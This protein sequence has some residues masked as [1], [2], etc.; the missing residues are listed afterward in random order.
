[1]SSAPLRISEPTVAAASIDDRAALAAWR[2]RAFALRHARGIRD[3]QERLRLR[4]ALAIAIVCQVLFFFGLQQWTRPHFEVPE[5]VRVIHL[6][7]IDPPSEPAPAPQAPPEPLA[8]T[9]VSAP[10][11]VR[12]EPA[13]RPAARPREAAPESRHESV[14]A[15]S[16]A[17]PSA[18]PVPGVFDRS[19]RVLL[20]QENAVG[21]AE[22]FAAQAPPEDYR[23]DPMAHLAP[24]PYKPTRFDK[25]W[26]PDDETLLGEWVRKATRK[27]VYDTRGGTRITC[28]AF[29]FFSACG[30]GP[31]PRVTI[32]EL[33]A[34]RVVPPMPRNSA[35]DPYQ[36]PDD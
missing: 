25:Y 24:L 12:I 9:E 23:P 15:E 3:R 8:P 20:P 5:E 7:L 13:I 16:N 33:K 19:G 36:Q 4:W 21:D 29:L 30:W 11:R 28:E 31:T 22:R 27:T 14:A 18:S 34:M 35:D 26:K 2:A 1:L 10:P 32:E 17:K 6:R